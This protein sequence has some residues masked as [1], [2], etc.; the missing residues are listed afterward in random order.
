M[1]SNK[2]LLLAIGAGLL[3]ILIAGTLLFEGDE[4][5]PATT[6][7]VTLPVPQPAPVVVEVTPEPEP[8]P[9]PES[10][11]EP[12]PEPVEPAFVLPL[13]N[14]SDGLIRDGLVSLSRHEGMN[15]W[16]AVNDLI[17]KFVGFTNGVSEGR[18]VR[19][20]VEILAPR[21]KFL[22][23]QIDEETYS[24]DPKS[25]DRYDLFVNI[26]ESL[27]SEGTAELYVLV[28]PLLDQAYSELGL[29]NG[30]MNN[31][32]FAAI[33]R[34]LEV[35]VIAGE[36]RLT[37]PVVMYEFEDSALERL[38]PAQKQVIRMGPINT[39]RLQRKLSEISR[40]LRV[41]LETN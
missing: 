19:N 23:S 37:Q 1:L 8:E 38:S 29:P 18:V 27:D 30:S 26:F 33:G 11:P 40:A 36:V 5:A 14:A 4:K 35:P 31:T 6:Q 25:Y 12:E 10:A 16:V 3:V 17:R 24:I 7:I 34:L 9:E 2:P 41:A 13:L 32:L 22:V 20:P 21:G 28:L 15:Q 39:Q